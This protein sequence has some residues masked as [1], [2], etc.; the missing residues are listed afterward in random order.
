MANEIE[1]ANVIHPTDV[2]AAMMSKAFV[3]LDNVFPLIAT[4]QFPDNTNVI[5]FP[6]SGKVE[7]GAQNQ[8]TA[9]SFGA[10]DEITDSA[11]TCTGAMKSQAQKVT[12]HNLRFGGQFANIQRNINEAA[13]AVNRLAAADLKTLFSSV[14]G[15]VTATSVLVKDNLLDARYTVVSGIK[16]GAASP[17]LVGMFDYKGMNELAK[18]LTDTSASAFTGQVD[19]G[20]LGMA[21]AGQPKGE[22]FDI[23]LFE[24]DGLPTSGGD[25]VACVWDPG[26]AFCAGI[27]GANG[28]Q[29]RLKEP[30]S[31]E[32]WT[33]VFMWTFW[34]IKE[35]N[36][37]AACKVLSDT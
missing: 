20:V 4:Q 17:K 31:Q 27:D 6:K 36:D 30:E 18:E 14:S 26:I 13:L 23:V 19:L 16:S 5:L 21:R 11:I 3:A 15:G 2:V 22:L 7:A 9:Y 33:E 10:D 29:V 12:I 37:A 35:W 24:T 8:S 32:P 28:F 34:D 1:L 25:D